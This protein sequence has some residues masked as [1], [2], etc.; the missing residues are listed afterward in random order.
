MTKRRNIFLMALAAV[1]AFALSAAFLLFLPFNTAH[2]DRGGDGDW[3]TVDE[4]YS[5]KNSK[6]NERVLKELYTVL[7]GAENFDDL[8]SKVSAESPLTSENFRNNN[9]GKNVSVW[10]G[11]KKWDAVYLTKDKSDNIV[12]DLW[13]SADNVSK[14]SQWANHAENDAEVKYPSNMYS[15]SL[16]RVDALNNGGYVS[17]SGSALA[18]EKT[19]QNANDEYARFT[20]LSAE[21]S[22]VKYIVQPKDIAY[23][24]TENAQGNISFQFINTCPNDVYGTPS[25]ERWYND[26]YNYAG[27]GDSDKPESMYEAWKEDY[28]W[29]PSLAETGNRDSNLN[30]LWKT[31]STLRSTVSL[32]STGTSMVQMTWLRSGYF[33][34]ATNAYYLNITGTENNASVSA[35]YCV[36]PAL[37]LNLTEVNTD[38]EKFTETVTADWK[39]DSTTFYATGGNIV[40]NIADYV[41]VK[42][43]SGR[44]LKYLTDYT[45]TAGGSDQIIKA[46]NYTVTITM[47]DAQ[48]YQFAGGGNTYQLQQIEVKDGAVATVTIND[49][50][51]GFGTFGDA[52]GEVLKYSESGAKILLKLLADDLSFDNWN[53]LTVSYGECTFDLNGHTLTTTTDFQV[54]GLRGTFILT[55]SSV[56]G[57]GK[58]AGKINVAI[59]GMTWGG[60]GVDTITLNPNGFIS[61]QDNFKA[62]AVKIGI[63]TN[64]SE[65][66]LSKKVLSWT[67][68]TDPTPYFTSSDTKCFY[69]S[70][71]ENAAYISKHT[72]VHD[73]SFSW[74]EDNSKVTFKDITCTQCGVK[75]SIEKETTKSTE[76]VSCTTEN[77]TYTA[78]IVYGNFSWQY[79]TDTHISFTATKTIEGCKKETPT[80]VWEYSADGD[81]LKAA[82]TNPEHNE[83][84]DGAQSFTATLVKPTEKIYTGSAIKAAVT[85]AT[86]AEFPEGY[87]VTYKCGGEPVDEPIN[88]GSYQAILTATDGGA[89]VTVDFEIEP[90]PLTI[91]GATVTKKT[92]DGDNTAT[93]TEFTFAG[94]KKDEDRTDEAISVKEYTAAFVSPNAGTS[95]KV[96]ITSVKLGGTA[97]GNYAFDPMSEDNAEI[98]GEIEKATA[99][100]SITAP[101]NAKYNDEEQR[102]EVTISVVGGK[103]SLGKD[104]YI[105]FYQGAVETNKTPLNADTYTVTVALIPSKAG[106]YTLIGYQTTFTIDKATTTVVWAD[107]DGGVYGSAIK[108]PTASAAGVGSDVLTIKVEIDETS[109]TKGAFKNAGGYIF[110]ASVVGDLAQNY[111]LQK[112]KSDL[113]TIS[114]ADLTVTANPHEIAYGDQPANGGV[115][116]GGFASGDTESALTGTLTFDY[117]DYTAFSDVGTYQI[118]PGGLSSENYTIEYKSGTLTVSK[119]A[120]AP[121]AITN[122]VYNGALQKPFIESS[123]LYSIVNEGGTTAGNYNV[124]LTLNDSN[125]YKWTTSDEAA[126][127]LTFTIE[128]AE[129]A[130]NVTFESVTIVYDGASHSIFISGDLPSGVSVTYENNDHTQAGVYPVIANFTGDEINY[131][132]IEPMQAILTISQ[133]SH[134]LSGIVF[135]DVRVKYDG[136]A[137]SVYIAGELPVNVTVDYEGNGKTEPNIYTVTAIFS[138]PDGEFDRKTATLT[139]LRTQTQTAPKGESGSG[140]STS[141]SGGSGSTGSGGSTSGSGSTGESGESV[142]EVLIESEEGFDPTLELVVEKMESSAR[143]YLAWGQDEISERY[144]IK[145]CKDGVEVPVEGKVTVRLLIPASFRDKDFDLLA[146]V[147]SGAASSAYSGATYNGAHTIAAA[148]GSTTATSATTATNVSYTREGN[149]VVFE[150]DGLT[151]YVFKKVYTPY[152]PV[153][154]IAS[155][156]LFVDV[157]AIVALAV[158]LKKL[159][160]KKANAEVR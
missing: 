104:D 129:Y 32:R 22:L 92:Y 50:I 156:V 20:M 115:T 6:F 28:L 117:G 38:S 47:T 46:G 140:G 94:Y 135:A 96:T 91:T 33:S 113:V 76:S 99:N 97:A 34:N 44:K 130:L 111:I 13:Q 79:E 63:K 60:G 53:T 4:I 90:A 84:A 112:D 31:N 147:K 121:P 41:E 40:G 133:V 68:E 45:V 35:Q 10:F 98:T 123:A 141:G 82:C 15:T 101:Q 74:T 51:I 71:S 26:D 142:P 131:Y 132:P 107:T 152:F 127:T 75:T 119:K 151:E 66:L 88:A 122:A 30:G 78:T 105:I 67:G 160:S 118:T 158:V 114:K 126:I 61:V 57:N 110:V 56:G 136:E 16:I 54:N 5:E 48:S 39:S 2:A 9:G 86:E 157:L 150:S 65:V 89:S 153:L 95:V 27:K 128:K 87:S 24:E 17:T 81:S 58:I 73:G 69:K 149:Y 3:V 59:G 125:N 146:M 77:I 21:K 37:H 159:S 72:F 23:Q 1:M 102:V 52:Y 64:L 108:T 14:T 25:G 55:D 8:S 120:I 36:R 144:S 80:H 154:I 103:T 19:E 42:T 145:L 148:L 11:G 124:T 29:L 7:A 70:K 12:L 83:E 138:D 62:P 18:E 109:P 43:E 137:H 93:I 139:I 155:G 85:G 134:D 100:V 106:N 116:Y 143:T 49:K